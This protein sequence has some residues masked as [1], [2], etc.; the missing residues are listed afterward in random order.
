MEKVVLFRVGAERFAVPVDRVQSIERI[1]ELT[2][3][4]YAPTFVKGMTSLRGQIVPVIDLSE[5]FSYESTSSE[6]E[7]RML[8][9]LTRDEW[10]GLLVDAAQDVIEVQDGARQPAPRVGLSL[11]R[12]FLLGVI[13]QNEQLI[14]MLDL[15]ALFTDEE[16]DAVRS[17]M[18]MVQ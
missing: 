5:R 18:E 14:M 15:D 6:L 7:R 4:P 17:G 11:R 13:R 8:V 9:V 1:P 10:V 16:K 2:L 3:V 12:E